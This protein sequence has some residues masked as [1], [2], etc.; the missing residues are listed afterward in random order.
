MHSSA[1]AATSAN[2][3]DSRVRRP[4][5]GGTDQD[6]ANRRAEYQTGLEHHAADAG[7][8]PELVAAQHPREQG[9]VHRAQ[10]RTRDPT[11]GDRQVDRPQAAERDDVA[12]DQRQHERIQGQHRTRRRAEL[13]SRQVVD[14]VA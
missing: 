1:P 4:F 11:D 9:V 2:T 10:E 7:T 8:A 12:G 14:Q 13:A 3:V 5:A 6:A